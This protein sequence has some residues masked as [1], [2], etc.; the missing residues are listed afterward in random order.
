MQNDLFPQDITV[1]ELTQLIKTTLEG[2]FYGLKVTGEI[3]NFRPAS[4]GHWF[5]ALKDKDAVIGAVMFKNALWR[6]GFIPKDGD[7]VTVTGSI[8]VYPPRGTYQIKCDSMV[9]TGNGE[10]LALLEERKRQFDA[11]GYFATEHKIPLPP[12][13]KKVGIVTSPTGAALQDIL[14]ILERRAPSLDVVI[15]P[16][17]VQ[18][19]GAASTIAERIAEANL[20]ALCD[21]L[22]VARGGGS[23]E[24]LLPFSEPCV[25]KAVYDSEIPVVSG[26]GHEIDWALCD[27]AADLRAPTPSA[28]AELVSKGYVE[29]REAMNGTKEA[30]DQ[31]IAARIG[32]AEDALG[33]VNP[34]KLSQTMT[35]SISSWEYQLANAADGLDHASKF[36][37]SERGRHLD[38]IKGK[39]AIASPASRLKAETSMTERAGILLSAAMRTNLDALGNAL[40]LARSQLSALNPLSILKRGYSVTTDGKGNIITRAADL[41]TGENIG[42]RFQDG[43]RKAIVEE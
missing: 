33:F 24:D 9:I 18:G 30:M 3:S 22:I 8:D 21:V 28:A 15:L 16:A 32:S 11:L 19:E 35:R 12:Y 40:L 20:F 23:I 6:V 27:Y 1:G 17:I 42:I 39:L 31:A 41:A 13:P 26:V 29:L 5:F 37:F 4:T 25:V 34:T 43:E 36:F 7:K 2:S 10:I 38:Q 14:Q